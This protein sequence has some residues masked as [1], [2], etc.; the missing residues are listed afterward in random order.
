[1]VKCLGSLVATNQLLLQCI[2]PTSCKEML[3][4]LK[5]DKNNL[6][7]RYAEYFPYYWHKRLQSNQVMKS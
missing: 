4:K 1:M 5:A 2:L 6:L 7:L 3:M